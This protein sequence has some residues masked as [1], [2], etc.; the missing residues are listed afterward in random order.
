MA[1]ASGWTLR[2]VNV[3]GELLGSL[4]MC[5]HPGV[6]QILTTT[7]RYINH[8]HIHIYI[9]EQIFILRLKPRFKVCFNLTTPKTL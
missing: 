2:V 1:K 9:I 4:D 7:T 6:G 8:A 5:H 3:L